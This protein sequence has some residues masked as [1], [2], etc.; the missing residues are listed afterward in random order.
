MQYFLHD[1][2]ILKVGNEYCERGGSSLVCILQ[3]DHLN[4]CSINNETLKDVMIVSCNEERQCINNSRNVNITKNEIN[5]MN[6]LPA[7]RKYNHTLCFNYLGREIVSQPL[8][9]SEFLDS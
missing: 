1:I 8:Q 4:E 7:K 6:S 5:S 2:N 3:L 9:T